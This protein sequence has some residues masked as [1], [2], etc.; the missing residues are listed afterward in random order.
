MEK[1]QVDLSMPTLRLGE[2]KLFEFLE[3]NI[4]VVISHPEKVL[5]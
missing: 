3:V 1:I 4:Q 5:L 2:I